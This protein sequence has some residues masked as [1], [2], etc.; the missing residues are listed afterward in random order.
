MIQNAEKLPVCR[1]ALIER[2]GK[3]AVNLQ[4]DDSSGLLV[5]DADDRL[6]I[7]EKA[8]FLFGGKNCMKIFSLGAGDDRFLRKRSGVRQFS[9]MLHLSAA[10]VNAPIRETADLVAV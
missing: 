9:E 3:G 7:V 8:V 1:M 4:T 5:F 6:V 10:P 2:G